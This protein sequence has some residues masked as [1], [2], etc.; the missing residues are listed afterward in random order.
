MN[1]VPFILTSFAYGTGPYLRAT[2]WALS[3]A[4]LL[5]KQGKAKHR[6]IV[7]LVYGK[8]QQSIMKE[9]L[10]ARMSDIILDETYGKLL[11][12]LFYGKES[13]ATYLQRWIDHVDAQSALIRDYLQKTYG[14][15]I[16]LE[17]HRSPRLTIGLAPAY[18]LTFGWQTDILSQAKGKP[19]VEIPE[20]V[21]DHA[22]SKFQSIEQSFQKNFLT[23]P[24]TF[25]H[26]LNF[27]S[28]IFDSQFVPP[29]ISQPS[30]NA[31]ALSSGIYVTVTGIPGLE[32]L[33]TEAKGLGMTI[34]SNDPGALTEAMKAL[35]DVIGNPAIK[36]HFARSGWSS[37]WLSLLTDTPFVAAPWD[38]K[39]DPEIYFNNQCIESLGIGTVYRGQSLK[40]LLT[41]GEKQKV[42]MQKLRSALTKKYKTLDGTT[43]ASK[44]VVECISKL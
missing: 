23:D 17:L 3:V 8:K 27:Q 10:G 2:E 16:A 42:E 37:V 1:E 38:P 40:E 7:P 34:Y 31:D 33:F 12:P 11:S 19:E 39:D 18:A 24:G 25:S 20:Q 22:I 9:V 15:A 30:P 36:L 43:L 41:E 35:P 29:T 14:N 13:Y 5:E 21:L 44:E 4:D 26:L 28:S 6:I 32:R